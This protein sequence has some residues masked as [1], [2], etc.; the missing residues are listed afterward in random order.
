MPKSLPV[1]GEM[2]K[3]KVLIIVGSAGAVAAYLLYK[4]AK[5]AKQASAVG[6]AYGYGATAYGYGEPA[7]GYYGYGY[8]YGATG[9]GFQPEPF[10]SE[11]GYGAYGYGYYNPYTGAW[12]GPASGGGTTGGTTTTTPPTTPTYPELA[13]PTRAEE[14]RAYA[15]GRAPGELGLIFSGGKWW[16]VPPPTNQTGPQTHTVTA[17][18]SQTLAATSRANSISEFQLLAY[19]PNLAYLYGSRKPI[20]RGTKVK[21]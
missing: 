2:N 20:P 7:E 4:H 6:G 5:A 16:R 13:S 9:G 1:V 14:L 19:N 10:G 18:G 8:G 12:I 21:V 15:S 3:G 11:Y 17:S